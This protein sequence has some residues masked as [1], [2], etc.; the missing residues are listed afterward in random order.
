MIIYNHKYFIFSPKKK[1]HPNSIIY[2]SPL[3][4]K[5]KEV[6]VAQL[7]APDDKLQGFLDYA[8]SKYDCKPIQ[9]GGECFLPNDV[10]SHASYALNLEYRATGK[11]NVEIGNIITIDPCKYLF[12][13]LFF[14]LM[15]FV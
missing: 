9:P 14:L 11:C 8:C 2:F 10:F 15:C 4:I 1:W 6:C 13:S 12:P 7:K 3:L 5:G